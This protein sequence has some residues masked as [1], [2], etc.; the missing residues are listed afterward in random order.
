ME[1]NNNDNNN[2]DNINNNNNIIS[3]NIQIEF[4]TDDKERLPLFSKLSDVFKPYKT[5]NNGVEITVYP[6][7]HFDKLSIITDPLVQNREYSFELEL[8]NNIL[9]QDIPSRIKIIITERTIDRNPV[10]KGHFH[11]PTAYFSQDFQFQGIKLNILVEGLAGHGKSSLL[12]ALF[13]TLTLGHIITPFTTS[14]YGVLTHT[15]DFA[16]VRLKNLITKCTSEEY[17]VYEFIKLLDVTFCDKRGATPY[18][19]LILLHDC[20][21]GLHSPG[22]NTVGAIKDKKNAVDVCILV[23][24]V[25]TIHSPD[26]LDIIRGKILELKSK[27]IDIIPLIVLTFTDEL[28]QSE[29]DIS[30]KAFDSLGVEKENMIIA[31]SYIN[32]QKVRDYEKDYTN[33][34][35]LKRVLNIAAERLKYKENNIKFN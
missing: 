16:F 21:E 2:N 18:D 11:I 32:G 6:K 5:Y 30:L 22:T 27:E 8:N 29:L 26:D 10:L 4:C 15:K 13:N 24:S 34:K 7:S 31:N 35:I 9:Q 12:N 1:N 33:F 23:V 28:T 20:F 14:K 17:S 3:D 19:N 25:K